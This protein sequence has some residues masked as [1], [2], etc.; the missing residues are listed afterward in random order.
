MAPHRRLTAL[1]RRV[2]Q[3][4]GPAPTRRARRAAGHPAGRTGHDDSLALLFLCCH[5]ALSPASQIALTLRAV[6]GLTT[7]EIA[8]AF[9]VPEATMAQRISRAKR[10][11]AD[12][13]AR[14]TL[15]DAGPDPGAARRGSP[16]ALPDLQRGVRRKLRPAD[17]ATR[18]RR[19]GDPADADAAPAAPRRR[20]GHGAAGA[21]APDPRASPRAHGTRR[22]ARSHSP[23]R[24]AACGTANSSPGASR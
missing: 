5:E 19:R 1:D 3:R 2:P 13:G 8:S 7:A 11:I 4:C 16:D 21:D 22:G 17:A 15:P 12:T 6:G 20:R 9:L 18:A 14:F 23:N 24:T 10:T